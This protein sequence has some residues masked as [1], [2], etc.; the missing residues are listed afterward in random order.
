MDHRKK[1]LEIF[2]ANTDERTKLVDNQVSNNV[3]YRGY[4]FRKI[5]KNRIAL[6]GKILDYGCGQ[7]R[8]SYLLAKEGYDVFGTDPAS[9]LIEQAKKQNT[10]NLNLQ[11]R[12]LE[13]EGESLP[14]ATYDAIICSSALEFVADADAVLKNLYRTLKPGGTLVVSLPNVRSLWRYYAKIRFGVKYDHFTV[15][16]NKWLVS[17]AMSHLKNA[18]FSIKSKPVFF[19]SAFDKYKVLRSLNRSSL[20]GTLYILI[21]EK[22]K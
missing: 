4:L 11:F 20:F 17:E 13:D 5:V 18:G 3:Y 21:G 6:G 14:N 7:G 1:T 2:N 19:E 9:G 22:E 16:K 8:I 10:D 12:V 15:Q